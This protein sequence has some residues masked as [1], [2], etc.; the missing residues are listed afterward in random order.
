MI[1]TQFLSGAIVP[2]E[3]YPAW[4]RS[5]LN[6]SP[7]PYM[8]YVPVKLFMGVY[9]GHIGTAFVIISFWLGMMILAATW[10]WKR[11]IRMYSGAGM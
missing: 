1:I 5:I 6:Y 4:F 8:T 7:F 9:E 2:L 11:G 3:I 10:T